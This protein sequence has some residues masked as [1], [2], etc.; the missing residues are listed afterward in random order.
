MA[1]ATKKAKQWVVSKQGKYATTG[2]GL[3]IR[4]KVYDTAAAAQY[5]VNNKPKLKGG[6]V[7]P[8]TAETQAGFA[9]MANKAN[10]AAA[11]PSG[12]APGPAKA[13]APVKARAAKAAAPTA[14]N[15][16]ADKSAATAKSK[17]KKGKHKAATKPATASE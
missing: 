3:G 14:T 13:A 4:P 15:D 17:A 1:S 9:A 6:V 11:K 12:K 5:D 10:A 16:T 7:M 2:G 8:Y